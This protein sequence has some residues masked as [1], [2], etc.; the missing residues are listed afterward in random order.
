MQTK[1]DLMKESAFIHLFINKDRTNIL[2]R[3]D[4]SVVV[5]STKDVTDIQTL[6]GKFP[7][8]PGFE[9]GPQRSKISMRYM[10][11]F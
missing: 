8:Q 2:L 10:R 1:I 5:N 9:P 4:Y 6:R 7:P 11:C 3:E